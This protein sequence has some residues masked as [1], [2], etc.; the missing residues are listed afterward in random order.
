MSCSQLLETF[1]KISTTN[2]IEKLREM[3][4]E[5][6][7]EA[8]DQLY[9]LDLDTKIHGMDGFEDYYAFND[10]L[11]ALSKA[12]GLRIKSREELWVGVEGIATIV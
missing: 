2:S 10:V 6:E 7:L 12:I 4:T 11:W 1:E 8:H 9:H 5:I 3:Q